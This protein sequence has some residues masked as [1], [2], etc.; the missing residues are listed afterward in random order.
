MSG[1]GTADTLFLGC[2]ANLPVGIVEP[3]PARR[4]PGAAVMALQDS[5]FAEIDDVAAD[6]LRGNAETLRHHLDGGE[7]LFAHQLDDGRLTL[8][9]ILPSRF[10]HV[11]LPLDG[12]RFSR[13]HFVR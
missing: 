1:D 10:P 9:D 13:T 6:G 8:A 12:G 4:Q 5:P 7:T 11:S 2:V 3:V